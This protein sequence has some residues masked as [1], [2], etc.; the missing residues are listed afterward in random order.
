MPSITFELECPV[1][2][3]TLHNPVAPPCGHLICESCITLHVSVSTN[4]FETR[5]PSCRASFPDV[6]PNLSLI[7]NKYRVFITPPLRRVYL[8]DKVD[9]STA[10]ID[11]LKSE[12][13]C[14]ETRI[15]TLES[16]NENAKRES[17][18]MLDK[19]K[20]D[21]RLALDE[22][23]KEVQLALDKVNAEAQLALCEVEK[24]ARRAR[25]RA[26]KDAQLALDK[27]KDDLRLA[28]LSLEEC[29]AE[30]NVLRSKVKKS[31]SVRNKS[32]QSAFSTPSKDTSPRCG[33]SIKS[34]PK[35]VPLPLTDQS[36]NGYFGL[37][38]DMHLISAAQEALAVLS[39]S[40]TPPSVA[41]AQSGSSTVSTGSNMPS[42]A[43]N[44][45]TN[46]VAGENSATSNTPILDPSPT[47]PLLYPSPS[48][49]PAIQPLDLLADISLIPTHTRAL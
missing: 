23:K 37:A 17:C 39:F 36:L 21:A 8:R 29:R 16:N 24:K 4:P 15:K 34:W 1:C 28:N 48:T 11:D 30:N 46:S 44:P 49:S 31:R 20:E 2:W 14:L 22:A 32:G 26:N 7:P 3:D 45:A 9:N 42:H 47:P 19:A 18:V 33:T 43:T 12:I 41:S 25:D 13:V 6:L 5:C 40:P 38:N 27:A 10:V 35:H